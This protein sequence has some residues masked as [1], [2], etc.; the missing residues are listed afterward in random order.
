MPPI[1]P[2]EN[3]EQVNPQQ[4]TV[5]NLMMQEVEN[6]RTQNLEYQCWG[7]FGEEN[8]SCRNF[9][10]ETPFRLINHY[11]HTHLQDS[12]YRCQIC[13]FGGLRRASIIQHVKSIHMR[14]SK[15]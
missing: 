4:T 12:P 2:E 6:Q 13:G 14:K 11:R 9:T 3:V 7:N 10:F 1:I 8:N 15:K 5:Y